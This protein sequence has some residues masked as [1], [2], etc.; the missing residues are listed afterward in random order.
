MVD[1]KVVTNVAQ[2]GSGSSCEESF[3]RGSVL[4]SMTL[5]RQS[6]IAGMS[7]T[8]EDLMATRIYTGVGWEKR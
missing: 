3:C 5:L 8:K 6:P 7:A 4:S 1:R 2:S